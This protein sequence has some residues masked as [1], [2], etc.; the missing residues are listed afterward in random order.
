MITIGIIGAGIIS[1]RHID[2]LKAMDDVTI[3]GIADIVI[4]RAVSF[5]TDCGA[6]AYS[7][8]KQMVMELSIDAIIINLPHSLHEE[9]TLFCASKGIHIFVE[10]PLS[11][12]KQSCEAMVECCQQNH[13]I[14]Q[15]GHPQSFFPENICA[16][17]YVLSNE[18]G[19]LCM[20][21]DVRSSFYFDDKRPAW[22]FQNKQSGGGILMNFGAHSLDKILY[23]TGSKIKKISGYLAKGLPNYEIE[24]SAQMS[25][26]TESG[27][28]ASVTLCG[29]NPNPVN[30]TTL[31][32]TNGV[33]RL[34][35]GSKLE[36]LTENGFETVCTSNI[37]T[38]FSTQMDAFISAIKNNTSP[39]IDGNYGLHIVSALEEIYRSN[40]ATHI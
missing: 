3:V 38:V 7:D 40:N 39:A 32:F 15:V 28:S 34:S 18:L 1:S 2:A 37:K 36:K 24:G 11:V 16:R 10:K 14:M 12:S 25:L 31:Y 8:Y 27:V 9:C 35:T 30:E 23:L 5:A 13:V 4:E 19:T 21:A 17:D 26:I 22:F 33:L 29:Y 6:K 20:I